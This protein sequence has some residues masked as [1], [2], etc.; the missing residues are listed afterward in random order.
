MDHGGNP[1]IPPF[2]TDGPDSTTVTHAGNGGG[3][4]PAVPTPPTGGSKKQHD[5]TPGARGLKSD[6]QSVG[7]SI[8]EGEISN[9]PYSRALSVNSVTEGSFPATF[10]VT[11]LTLFAFLLMTWFTVLRDARS[12]N[13]QVLSTTNT[14]VVSLYLYHNR[15]TLFTILVII[16]VD[17][18]AQP[19]VGSGRP[20]RINFVGNFRLRGFPHVTG[21]S[22]RR[23]PYT[24]GL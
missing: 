1:E 21:S 13:N 6:R 24:W 22:L 9:T 12:T 10:L 16:V 2:I 7:A 23:R 17:T 5:P 3:V 19:Q 18:R 8:E 11:L 14:T 4:S 15:E 20:H